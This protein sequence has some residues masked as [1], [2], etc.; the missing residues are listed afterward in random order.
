MTVSVTVEDGVAVVALDDGKMNVITHQVL[1]D[2]HAALDRAVADASS[3]CLRGNDRSLSAGFDLAVMTGSPDGARSLVSAGAELLI[4][5]YVHPQPT[6]VAVTGHALA[7]GALLV[8]ASDTRIAAD[9]PSK[10]GLNEV[11]IGMPLP[12]FAWELA[13]ARLSKRYLTRATIQGEVFNPAGAL[14][15]GYVDRVEADCVGAALA[16]ARRLGE[17]PQGA[18]AMTKRSIRQPMVDRVLGALSADI[19]GFAPAKQ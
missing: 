3:V 7:A 19:G 8:L 5:L 15:A 1:D 6:V 11:G 13:L 2:L 9:A 16:E 4:R 17:L 10:I 18:Y 14:A 12:M